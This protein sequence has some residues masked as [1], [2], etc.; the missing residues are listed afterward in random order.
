MPGRMPTHKWHGILK[1]GA[2]SIL[3]PPKLAY[4]KW[5]YTSEFDITIYNRI[6]QN[7]GF[8]EGA[9]FSEKMTTLG[10]L[11]LNVTWEALSSYLTTTSWRRPLHMAGALTPPISSSSRPPAAESSVMRKGGTWAAEMFWWGRFF[12]G[13]CMIY[14]IPGN[15]KVATSIKYYWGIHGTYQHITI[16]V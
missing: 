7:D 15:T 12:M 9:F 13:N 14:Q 6:L 3:Q 4:I 10:Y 11:F 8:T 1:G 16:Y 2:S 5:F